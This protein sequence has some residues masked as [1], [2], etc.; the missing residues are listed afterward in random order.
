M[1]RI[2][3]RTWLYYVLMLLLFC[4][5]AYLLIQ[6]G[7]DVEAN[8]HVAKQNVSP[9][10]VSPATY[11]SDWEQFKISVS[12]NIGEPITHLLLQIIAILL[13]SRLLTFLFA[14]I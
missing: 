7:S 5:G 13:V 3:L 4:V 1:S 8:Y 2:K 9:Q 14:K 10:V 12:H 6:K 11:L